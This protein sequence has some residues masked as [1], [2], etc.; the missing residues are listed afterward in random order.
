MQHLFRH[1]RKGATAVGNM[2]FPDG[3]EEFANPKDSV[4][5]YVPAPRS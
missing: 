5:E 2:S 1:V 3:I 4:V